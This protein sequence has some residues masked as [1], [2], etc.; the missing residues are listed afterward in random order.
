[1]LERQV[2]VIPVMQQDD[3]VMSYE[4]MV[5]Q[6][7]WQKER[8][9]FTWHEGN[10]CNIV[11]EAIDKHCEHGLM[12]HTALYF[13][14]DTREETYTFG[15][16]Q[17]LSSAFARGLQT[18]GVHKGDRVFIFLP[19][20]PEYYVAILGTLR[21]G[22][23]AGPLFEAFMEKAVKDRLEDSGAKVIVTTSEL[24]PRIPVQELPE[25][26]YVVLVDVEQVDRNQRQISY[27]ALLEQPDT[28]LIE[29]VDKEDGM[30]LQYTS[31]ST[32]KPKGVL[33]SH[34]AMVHMKATGKLVCSLKAN[35]VYWCVA[36][37]GWI[38][39][40]SA[41]MWSPWLNGVSVVMIGGRFDVQ[42]WYE[43]LERYKV[44][45]WFSAP[46]ALR[47][48][49]AAGDHLAAPYDFSSIRHIISAGEPLNPEIA[50]WSMQVFGIPV[51]DNWWMTETGSAVI[52]NF[53]N[54]EIKLGSMGKPFPGITVDIVD[55]MGQPLKA[56]EIGNL[57]IKPN[58]P[59]QMKTIW[60]NH[61]KYQ[62]YFISGW[63]FSG[64]SAYRDE[65][66][67]FWFAGRIDD[68]INT[69]GERVGPFEVESKLV[70][71]PA[72]AEAGVIGFPDPVRGE[73]VKAFVT[74]RD[75]FYESEALKQ[76]IMNFVREKLAAHARPRE[77]EIRDK[78]PKTR[79]G[80]IM[81]RV[82]KT[83][84]MQLPMGDISTIDE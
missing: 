2:E 17:K 60:N 32:G 30:M 58:W 11:Y 28:P 22:A 68:I 71:H 51:Y 69:M 61:K 43:T 31:G 12:D 1:M 50:R 53:P 27:R 47:M 70:E 18:L 49:M 63:Y 13:H 39:G 8:D 46:T 62:E 14:N 77:I 42:K 82:L 79:S 20:M 56:Y 41:G 36:D 52:A 9:E 33:L 24:L 34:D 75:G 65:D 21:I 48:L 59:G 80:K 29:W 72:V 67:Y 37:P 83:R 66:G 7:S 74:L 78:L 15:G 76:D 4:R 16:M 45:V 38:T 35:D 54:M 25:L 73:I 23:I 26:Q 64:D 19:R 10:R 84:E 44:T 5:A 57:V 6:F 55:N 81:R 3:D 40:T